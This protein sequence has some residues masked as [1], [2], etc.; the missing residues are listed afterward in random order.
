MLGEV[1]ELVDF[2]FLD[3]RAGRRGAGRRRVAGDEL[4]PRILAEAL[5]AYEDVRVGRGRAARGHA[6]HRRG[7][8]PQAGQGPGADPGGRHGAGRGASPCSTRWRCSAATRRAAAW[9]VALDR[10]DRSRLMLFAPLRWALRIA[11]WSSRP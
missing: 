9:R 4:A 7:G 1:P 3:G 2:L 11:R 8:G 5:A 6:G 10:L